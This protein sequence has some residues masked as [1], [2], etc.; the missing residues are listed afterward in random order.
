MDQFENLGWKEINKLFHFKLCLPF[1]VASA[2]SFAMPYAEA[3]S[4]A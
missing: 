4:K 1:Q 2:K 3:A